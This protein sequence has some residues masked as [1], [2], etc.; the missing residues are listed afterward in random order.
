MYVLQCMLC[1]HEYNTKKTVKRHLF[2][3]H[4]IDATGAEL[5]KYIYQLK[6]EDVGLNVPSASEMEINVNDI[7]SD[8]SLV[9]I[10]LSHLQKLETFKNKP[11]VT[12]TG[13]Y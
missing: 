2:E 4:N 11:K 5:N 3:K 7:L 9:S 13:I 10:D 8:K 6:P 1:N 12:N